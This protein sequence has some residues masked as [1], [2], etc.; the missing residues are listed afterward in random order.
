M[1]NNIHYIGRFAP[2]P[3]GPMH[4]GSLVTA[5][6]SFLEAKLNTG[7][8]LLRM[9]DLDKPREIP[10][11]ADDILRTLDTYGFSWDGEV[12]YQSK[13]IE[14]YKEVLVEMQ[15]KKFVYPCTCSRKVIAESAFDLGFEGTIY[16]KTCLYNAPNT[17]TH[18]AFRVKTS[19]EE[20]GFVDKVQDYFSQNIATEIGDFVI[21]RADG[22][23]AYQL[24][25]IVDDDYQGVTHIVR[26]SDLLDCTPRQIYLQQLLKYPTPVYTHVPIAVNTNGEKLSK[27][28]LAKPI[29]SQLEGQQLFSA[30]CFLGQNPPLEMQNATLGELW[31]WGF[32]NWS[33]AKIPRMRSIKT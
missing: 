4:F 1:S 19:N 2:S 32:A 25:V 14:A 26:G 6:A 27:Q 21:K 23:F 3:T 12:I 15:Q 13:R 33:L 5:V 20:I 31:R 22:F 17:D 7:K 28:T 11:A 9:E 18:A 24:A 16:P 8:W 10:G 30:L 29:S